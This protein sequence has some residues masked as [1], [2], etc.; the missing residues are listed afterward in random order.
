M[1]CIIYVFADAAARSNV[2][3]DM[4]YLAGPHNV[5]VSRTVNARPSSVVGDV[6][7]TGRSSAT[8]LAPRSVLSINT[9]L[10]ETIQEANTQVSARSRTD[11]WDLM[12]LSET[13]ACGTARCTD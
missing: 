12:M 11:G 5:S 9:L 3:F 6:K 4:V 1:S 7:F 10:A 13:V 2:M 8:E